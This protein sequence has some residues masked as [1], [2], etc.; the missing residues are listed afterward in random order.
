M[1]MQKFLYRLYRFRWPLILTFVGLCFGFHEAAVFGVFATMTCAILAFSILFKK[2]YRKYACGL[3][4]GSGRI[5]KRSVVIKV[6]GTC[7]ACHGKGMVEKTNYNDILSRT[8]E[9][10]SEHAAHLRELKSEANSLIKDLKFSS[11]SLKASTIRLVEAK[12]DDYDKQIKFKE[13]VMSYLGDVEK[14]VHDI[15]RNI[16]M[17]QKVQVADAH[18]NE[19]FG[20]ISENDYKDVIIKQG[21]L[22]F[23]L[24]RL[25]GELYSMEHMLK[26]RDTIQVTEDMSREIDSLTANLKA[27]LEK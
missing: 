25:E 2:T 3:C 26:E 1:K 21:R 23:D 9:K 24:S 20:P 18:L 27:Y 5:G 6:K 11:P 17:L 10:R 12:L 16:H 4:N 14:S 13:K 7:Y 19:K 8:A 22:E 15:L